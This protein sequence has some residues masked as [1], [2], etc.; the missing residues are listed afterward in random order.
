MNEEMITKARLRDLANR[1]YTQ[2][3]YTY[4]SFLTPA[5]LRWLKEIRPEL[6]Y[7][8]YTLFGGGAM[9][10]RQMVCF[11][12]EEMFGYSPN[13]PISLIKVEPLIDKFSDRLNHRDFLG[14]IM[15]LGLERSV[16][17]DIRVKDEKIAYVYCTEGIGQYICDNLTR[18]KHTNVKCHICADEEKNM[19]A[20]PVLVDLK[21]IVASLRLDAIVAG[22]TGLSRGDTL[23]LFYSKKVSLN[24]IMCEKNSIILKENDIFSVRGYGKFVFCNVESET[25]KGRISIH[26]KKWI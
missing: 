25:R 15:N 5:E 21:I 14:S 20:V 17:G 6:G 1:A 23:K 10:E 4:S 2:N 19:Q 7:I 8:D 24:G 3:V 22:V 26:I 12:S 13:F 16:L 9:C 11:G 18:I